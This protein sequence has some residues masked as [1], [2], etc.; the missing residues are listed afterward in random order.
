MPENTVAEQ[1]EPQCQQSVRQ[2]RKLRENKCYQ[3]ET[4][5]EAEPE[6]AQ[7]PHGLERRR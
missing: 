1:F 7:A 3:H 6:L 2:H 4:R 5:L